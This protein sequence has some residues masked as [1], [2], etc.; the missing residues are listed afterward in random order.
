MSQILPYF[1]LY[2]IQTALHSLPNSGAHCLFDHN[3]SKYR[4]LFFCKEETEGDWNWGRGEFGESGEEWK[5]ER[6]RGESIFNKTKLPC[7]YV[8]LTYIFSVPEPKQV[9]ADERGLILD[10]FHG[11][12][13]TCKVKLA[14]SKALLHVSVQSASFF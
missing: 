8:N 1:Y 3:F 13:I 11:K 6:L 2:S 10:E 9:I 4:G 5:E 12:C 14:H 7:S